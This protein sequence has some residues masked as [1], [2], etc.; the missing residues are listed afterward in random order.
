MS[1]LVLL[2]TAPHTRGADIETVLMPG[3]VIEAH[4]KLE[5]TCSNCHL[6]FRKGT[7]SRLCL[8]CHKEVRK[9]IAAATGYHGRLPDASRVS[10]KSCHSEHLGRDADIVRLDP[11]SF[12][13]GQTDFELL[14]AHL[15]APCA[16][17][18]RAD[19]KYSEAPSRCFSC[20]RQQDRHNGK[21]G[22]QCGDCHGAGDW[23][24]F[25]FD[26][27]ATDF[28]LRGAHRT[29][30]CGGCHISGK[31]KNTP[32]QC[33]SCHALNDVHRGAN[34]TQCA[35]CH[36]ERNWKESEFRH[37]RDTEFPLKGR[38]AKV[39]C[40]SCHVD[41]VRDKTPDTR[42][43]ACHRDDDA[44]HGRYGRK[45]RD[46][47]D[48]RGWKS[49][50]FDHTRSTDFPL[51]GRHRELVCSA[52]HRG[53][54]Y[55]EELA[56]ECINCNEL[57]DV[58][59]AQEGKQC[60]RCHVSEGWGESIVF[61]HGITRFPLLGLHATVPCEECHASA[62]FRDTPQ[63]CSRCHSDDDEH[64]GTLGTDCHSCHNPTGWGLWIFDHRSD[65]GFELDG[66]HREL[67]CQT[68]HTTTTRG[69][70]RQS[71]NCNAC[72]RQDDPHDGHFGS[73][74][75]RCHSTESFEDVQIQH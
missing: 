9:D 18:H 70:L 53:D 38:H 1:L 11:L 25:R 13:H 69:A 24:K 46:C 27:D 57:D 74:C 71:G 19:R 50:R 54:L 8:D 55:R 7:Q 36:N 51:R 56:V 31:Y 34:G 66:A 75:V 43:S 61:D 37:G 44:H 2:V 42:C 4:A 40:Q 39:R 29:T 23:R 72:H 47:H 26:H 67:H 30:D 10:C 45:C 5:S 63:A 35:D 73:D 16:A 12:D 22:K 68:C 20:H 59:R 52:C 15:A 60:E 6:R 32:A 49:A 65:T 33:N 21:L 17:C 28:A 48:E 14:E 58:H 41:P 3:Q 64:R 62:A